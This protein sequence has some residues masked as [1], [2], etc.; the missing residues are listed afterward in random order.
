[1][2]VRFLTTLFSP[3][4]DTSTEHEKAGE[5]GTTSLSPYPARSLG[6]SDMQS[7]TSSSKTE[8]DANSELGPVERVLMQFDARG[9]DRLNG[10]GQ[11]QG[12]GQIQVPGQEGVAAQGTFRRRSLSSV[13][14]LARVR[15]GA[16]TDLGDGEVVTLRREQIEAIRKVLAGQ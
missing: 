10:Q 16:R 8:A 12:Q 14:N 11:G 15:E 1:V 3:F 13:S 2:P 4:A 7:T 9:N 6:Q 5:M